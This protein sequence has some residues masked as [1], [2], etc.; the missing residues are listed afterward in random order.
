MKLNAIVVLFGVMALAHILS[1]QLDIFYEFSTRYLQIVIATLAA[2]LFGYLMIQV[3]LARTFV[4]RAARFLS[5]NYI[6][7]LKARR[8]F[9]ALF[10]LFTALTLLDRYLLLG[11]DFLFPDVVMQYR[12]LLT[13][14]GGNN[15]I[16]GLSLGNFFIFMI[17]TFV[18]S[19]G[20][21]LNTIKKYCLIAIFLIDVYLS[22]SRSALFLPILIV[23]FFWAIPQRL[24]GSFLVK[25][26]L[27]AVALLLGFILIGEITGKN[28]DELGFSVYLAAPVHAFDVI[29][30]DPTELQGY[31]LSFSPLHAVLGPLFEFSPLVSLPNVMTPLP[32]NVYTIFGV[33]Y[34]DFGVVGLI[35]WFF[36]F[37]A[38]SAF[39]EKTYRISNAE[40]I[41]VY[42]A[43][44]MSVLTLSVFYDYYT[45]SGV[46][47]MILLLTP[48][49]FGHSDKKLK[50]HQKGTI[51]DATGRQSQ[52]AAS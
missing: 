6:G 7:A 27:V 26:G 16:K 40:C 48:F 17:P 18:I 20:D 30:N 12:V 42:V 46:V 5:A 31:W 33:Y 21:Q 34:N 39:S 14:E 9:I 50:N 52:C 2:F 32:T 10:L 44:N 29:L 47:W 4:V 25:T 45:S 11:L 38:L 51:N 28:T 37:G 36:I 3:V 15:A 35:A 23:F 1:A 43:L 13:Q 22:S 24:N 49:F 41:R 19:Y 8:Y